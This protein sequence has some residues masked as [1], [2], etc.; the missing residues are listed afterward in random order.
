MDHIRIKCPKLTCQ[1][2]LAVPTSSRGKN[3]R[4]KNCGATIRVPL[5]SAAAAGAPASGGGSAPSPA[6]TGSG[7]SA[8][9]GVPA[10]AAKAA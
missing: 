2:I 9:N 6:S 8:G 4:C 10:K 7:Q 1:K 5:K 3:V